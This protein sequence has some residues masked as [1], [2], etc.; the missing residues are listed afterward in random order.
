[1]IHTPSMVPSLI[2]E[3]DVHAPGPMQLMALHPGE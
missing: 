1:M 3:L 2:F